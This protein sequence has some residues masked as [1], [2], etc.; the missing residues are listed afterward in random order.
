MVIEIQS[1]ILFIDM[2]LFNGHVFVALTVPLPAELVATREAE[3]HQKQPKKLFPV[4]AF[5]SVLRYF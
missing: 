5:R 2:L 1:R 4:P 3:M